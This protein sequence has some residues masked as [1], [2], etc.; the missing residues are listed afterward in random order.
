M[1]PWERLAGVRWLS[2]L[3]LNFTL[4]AWEANNVFNRTV[5]TSGWAF[6]EDDTIYSVFLVFLAKWCSLFYT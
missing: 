4:H 6:G 1:V 2:R 5:T 3:C